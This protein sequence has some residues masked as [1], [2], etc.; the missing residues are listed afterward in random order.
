MIS[1]LHIKPLLKVNI[2]QSFQSKLSV[3]IL[4]IAK[5]MLKCLLFSLKMSLACIFKS[6][7]QLVAQTIC[8]HYI[9][10]SNSAGWLAFIQK[11][12][13]ADLCYLTLRRADF[14]PITALVLAAGHLAHLPFHTGN[15]KI[16][17][18][19]LIVPC[20]NPA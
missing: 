9:S 7:G 16:N 13:N 19:C 17:V 5:Q 1:A 6:C 10:S 11:P 8:H 18:P 15:V 4:F 12:F 2:F 3:A 20:T 14:Y